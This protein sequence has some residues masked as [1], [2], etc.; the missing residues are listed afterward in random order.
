MQR[1]AE[2]TALE[3]DLDMGFDFDSDSD[4]DFDSDSDSE[5]GVTETLAAKVSHNLADSPQ[6]P[7][8]R[9]LLRLADPLCT[10]SKR[11]PFRS[12]PRHTH[13]KHRFRCG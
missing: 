13:S 10:Q 1:S 11:F 8:H 12:A 6:F 9:S 3:L 4:S 5:L 7:T 2:D